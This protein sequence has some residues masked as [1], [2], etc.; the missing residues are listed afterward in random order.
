M[1][2]IDIHTHH[3]ENTENT[4]NAVV[5]TNLPIK[6]T[7]AKGYFSIGIH[8]YQTD[9]HWEEQMALI[10]Q[11]AILPQIVAIGE[12]GLDKIWIKQKESKLHQPLF[13][14][15]K[16]IM[17]AHI[18]CSEKCRK[19]LIIHCVKAFNELIE[20]KK[21]FRPDMPWIIHGFRNNANI[22]RALLAEG[23]YLSFGE[24]FQEEALL[25]VPDSRLFIETDE[26]KLHIEQIINKIA[27]CRNSSQEKLVHIL[28]QNYVHTFSNCNEQTAYTL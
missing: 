18:L 16:Q 7:D 27:A 24:Y 26:S 28:R 20:L 14:I 8:P 10:Q 6:H 2:P 3:T 13:E 19:P 25:T 12:C 11:Y 1:I 9:E 15:Q 21:T 23:F 22:A 17:K 4:E 5:N